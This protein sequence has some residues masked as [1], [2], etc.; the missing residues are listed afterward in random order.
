MKRKG[1]PTQS[2][3]YSVIAEKK[4]RTP[5]R[6][7]NFTVERKEKRGEPRSRD[8]RE[9]Q[10]HFSKR[11]ETMEEGTVGRGNRGEKGERS[12]TQQRRD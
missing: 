12:T 4:K 10:P 8:V 9:E 3:S 1:G 7:G 11:E 2:T 5:L 6:M